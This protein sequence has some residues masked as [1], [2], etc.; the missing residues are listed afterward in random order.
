MFRRKIRFDFYDLDFLSNL[1]RQFLPKCNYCDWCNYE[2]ISIDFAR[3]RTNLIVT[4][5]FENEKDY[6][7]DFDFWFCLDPVENGLND[8]SNATILKLFEKEKE[9]IKDI[10]YKNVFCMCDYD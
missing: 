5:Y 4:L 10:I 9:K 2:K 8:Y 7:Y 3:S 6:K 1:V